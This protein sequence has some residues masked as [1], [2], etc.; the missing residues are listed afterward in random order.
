MNST[1]RARLVSA[2]QD[3]EVPQDESV[4]VAQ[5]TRQI[6]KTEV[7]CQAGVTPD[8]T[9]TFKVWLGARADDRA[10][11]DPDLVFPTLLKDRQ[12][13]QHLMEMSLID[14]I[15]ARAGLPRPFVDGMKIDASL[16]DEDPPLPGRRSRRA[17]PFSASGPSS[18]QP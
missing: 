7:L 5:W 12:H 11:P 8:A 10:L 4:L 14:E 15:S 1:E 16:P 17:P 6:G 2:R 3:Q 9:W 18:A 13:A